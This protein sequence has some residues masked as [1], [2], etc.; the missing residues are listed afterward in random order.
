MI[1]VDRKSTAS[2]DTTT[3]ADESADRGANADGF[4]N[5]GSIPPVRSAASTP[6]SPTASEQAFGD[7]KPGPFEKVEEVVKHV[8]QEVEVVG[9]EAVG[10]AELAGFRYSVKPYEAQV[11]GGLYRGSRLD[12]AGMAALKQQGIRGVVN[13]CLENNEDQARAEKLGLEALHVPILD[14]SP[15]SIAQMMSFINFAKANPPTYVHCEAGKGRTGTAVAC[16]RIAVDGWT[17][18]A[19]IAEARSFGLSLVNQ[20][21]FIETFGESIHGATNVAP[22]A[23]P[24]AP[25]LA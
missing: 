9:G 11:D 12:D 18:E 4:T 17:T 21:A 5:A 24:S 7:H 10:V 19:A 8:G 6:P 3:L 22:S 14:N 15:P 16:Y 23:A 2:A 13:L 25:E 1:D 20:L